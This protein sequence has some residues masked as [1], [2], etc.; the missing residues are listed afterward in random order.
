[1]DNL[2]RYCEEL[3][4]AVNFINGADV[5]EHMRKVIRRALISELDSKITELKEEMRYERQGKPFTKAELELLHAEL[6]GKV[7]RSWEDER[8]TLDALSVKLRRKQKAVKTKAI[9]EGFQAAVDWWVN[10]H[11]V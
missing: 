1:M 7:A 9:S 11:N 8:S 10:R 6:A 3:K 2:E 5:D 4:A